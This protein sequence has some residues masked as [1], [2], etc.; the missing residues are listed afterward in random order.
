MEPLYLVMTTT[1]IMLL[2]FVGW[3]GISVEANKRLDEGLRIS[4][5]G[6]LLFLILLVLTPMLRTLT[7]DTSCDTIW[8]LSSMLFLVNLLF[9][10]YTMTRV[11]DLRYPDSVSLNAAMFASVL[12]ASRLSSNL[13][14]FS[15]TSL[16][17]QLFALFPII[18]RSLRKL[19]QFSDI[20][21]SACLSTSSAYLLYT[22]STLATVIHVGAFLF[23]TFVCPYWLLFV[24]KFKKYVFFDLFFIY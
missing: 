23:I 8:A 7:K 2:G 14:V 15:L 21:M 20:I 1:L 6:T 22:T 3:L 9:H 24:Q 12:L 10:D 11:A 17:V 5:G 19:S 4:K 16:A 13:H 18:R